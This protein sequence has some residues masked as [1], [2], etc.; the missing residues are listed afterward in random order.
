MLFGLFRSWCGQC[1][2]VS[3]PRPASTINVL[4]IQPIIDID[5]D[6]DMKAILILLTCYSTTNTIDI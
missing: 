2:Y 5:P 4:Y 3:S 1:H 6:I